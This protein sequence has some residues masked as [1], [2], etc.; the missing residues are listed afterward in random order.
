MSRYCPGG[1]SLSENPK[2]SDR[3]NQIL[4]GD[5]SLR[6]FL[7]LC[8]IGS[9]QCLLPRPLCCRGCA[10]ATP[11]AVCCSRRR[12][13]QCCCC[14]WCG[15]VGDNRRRLAKSEMIQGSFIASLPRGEAAGW[16]GGSASV[17]CRNPASTLGPKTEGN[18]RERP[19]GK[20]PR[21]SS[22]LNRAAF[23]SL[24]FYGNA[25]AFAPNKPTL[26]PR[27]CK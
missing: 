2:N 5:V 8:R 22:H 26:T 20:Q 24:I 1:H 3:P 18:D 12:W 16:G 9:S 14:W 23:H 27:C 19:S 17:E 25:S 7:P 13:W 4:F 6:R 21:W 10:F 15:R 11:S